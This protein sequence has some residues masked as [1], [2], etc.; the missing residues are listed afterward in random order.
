MKKYLDMIESIKDTETGAC[1][2][3]AEGN[4]HYREY[5]EWV[6]AGNTPIEPQPSP[7][8]DLV[9]DV[10][11]ENADKKAD[12]ELE[13]AKSKLVSGPE[14]VEFVLDAMVALGLDINLLPTNSRDIFNTM[15]A[16]SADVKDKKAK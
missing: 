11:V 3:K 14:F 4:R 8:H 2:P 1:I 15:L 7:D 12:R 9:D 13:E 16:L 10:W 6:A 5:L